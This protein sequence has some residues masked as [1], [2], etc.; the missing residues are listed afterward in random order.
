MGL[1]DKLTARGRLDDR[2]E[3]EGAARCDANLAR[4][5]VTDPDADR[6]FATAGTTP[7]GDAH[8][9][10]ALQARLTERIHRYAG[11]KN[12]VGRMD[13]YNALFAGLGD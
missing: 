13:L 2:T 8:R 7:F 4:L 12:E 6:I 1:L 3:R 10:P 9:D 5:R 11:A